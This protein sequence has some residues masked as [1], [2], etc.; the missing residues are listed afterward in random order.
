MDPTLLAS[1][2]LTSAPIGYFTWSLLTSDA[3]MRRTVQH[4]LNQGM[5]GVVADADRPNPLLRLGRHLTP[6]AYVLKLDH[7]LALAGR[8]ASMPLA[9]VLT[10]KPLLGLAGGLA[11]LLLVQSNPSR[12]F[13]LLALFITVL[14]YFVPDLLLYSKGQERQKAMALELA[15]TLDQMLISVEAG[16]GFESAMQRAGETGK[17]PLADELVRTLQDM[18][19]GR[20]RREAYLAMAD[21]STIP[22]LRSFVKAIVQADA[23]GIALSGVLRTQAKVM[24]VKRRQRA[25]EK[26]MKLPVAVL[27]PLLLFIFPVLFIVILGPA[28][29]N[30]MD[31]FAGQ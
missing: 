13:V 16:L 2:L 18:Q 23:Y 1:L 9:K 7:L 4:N 27:F 15:N 10:A 21:R 22:E 26:A 24:R 14:G 17:G 12:L 5:A 29:L 30:V 25:E 6:Q 20:S 11:G 19:V 28:A 3:R 8:P 31:T